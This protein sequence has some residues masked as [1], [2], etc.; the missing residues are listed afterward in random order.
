MD[1]QDGVSCGCGGTHVEHSGEIGEA[2]CK[3]VSSLTGAQ[4]VSG[5]KV[6]IKKIQAKQGNIRVSYAVA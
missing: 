1:S 5:F 3:R 2:G 4:S 6:S